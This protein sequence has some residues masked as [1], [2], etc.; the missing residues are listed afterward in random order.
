[1][2]ETEVANLSRV[3]LNSYS[4]STKTI[5]SRIKERGLWTRT[6]VTVDLHASH[7]TQ[8]HMRSH[9][10]GVDAG[11]TSGATS[12]NLKECHA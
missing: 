2:W 8:V 12:E 9:A 7:A 6:M 1:M 3:L 10:C 11:Q 5:L 4:V